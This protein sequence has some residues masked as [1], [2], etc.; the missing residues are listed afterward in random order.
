MSPKQYLEHDFES[1]VVNVL[2]YIEGG[3]DVES[4]AKVDLPWNGYISFEDWKKMSTTD[5]GV[6][7]HNRH[8]SIFITVVIGFNDPHPIVGVRVVKGFVKFVDKCA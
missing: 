4:V 6:Q 5:Y 8:D 7:V 3:K 1:V 2:I